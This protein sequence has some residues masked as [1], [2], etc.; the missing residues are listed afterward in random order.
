MSKV[1]ETSGGDRAGAAAYTPGPWSRGFSDWWVDRQDSGDSRWVALLADNREAPVALVLGEGPADAEEIEANAH[2][3][4][5]A[6]TM[7]EALI[8]ADEALAQFTAFE[9]D[10]REIMGNTNF[11]IVKQ[12]REQVRAAISKAIPDQAGGR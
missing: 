9:T 12:R 10:A 3:I 11:E 5:A 6:P 8:A 7:L 2:L 4:A 1:Q